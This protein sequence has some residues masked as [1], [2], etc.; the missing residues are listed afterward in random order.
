M[1][2][3]SKRS[4]PLS[5]FV[6]GP[7]GLLYRWQYTMALSILHRAMGCVLSVGLLLLVYWLAAAAR[8]AQAYAQAQQVL[9]HPLAKLVL[10]FFSFAF[11]FHLMNGVRHLV[12]DAGYGFEKKVARRSGWTVFLG[13]IAVTV[14]FWVLALR[15]TGP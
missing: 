7:G 5:P 13:A 14:A 6:F 15:A 9:A 3:T 4:R 10:A 1:T 2:S 12:W 11:F 8:G